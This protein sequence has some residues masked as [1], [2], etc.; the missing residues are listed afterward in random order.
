M[1]A[2]QKPIQYSSLQKIF[3]P[4]ITELYT[5]S[6]LKRSITCIETCLL[7]GFSLQS[8]FLDGEGTVFIDVCLYT[9]EGGVYTMLSGPFPGL[10]SFLEGGTPVL[11]LVLRGGGGGLPHQQGW[12]THLLSLD[13]QNQDGCSAR[14]VCLLRL[15]RRTSFF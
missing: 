5:G 12:G 3:I 9:E 4:M 15:R 2:F 14:A 8:K 1:V 13:A 7:Q 6:K 10:W 11:S